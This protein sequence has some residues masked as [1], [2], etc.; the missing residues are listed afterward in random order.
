MQ[1][2]PIHQPEQEKEIYQPEVEKSNG[3]P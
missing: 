2:L 1:R 3:H